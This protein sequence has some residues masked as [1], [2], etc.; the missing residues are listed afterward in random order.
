MSNAVSVPVYADRV[1]SIVSRLGLSREELGSIVD[2]SPRS[3]ARWTSGSAAP[4]RMTKQR[5]LELAYVAEA[6]SEIIP[7]DRANAW[8]LTPNRLLGH[9]SPA[10]RIHEGQYKDVLDLIEALADG[11]VV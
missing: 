3:I 11:V 6:V 8:I 7:R 1:N 4:Q 5:L 9:S 2:A 10:V